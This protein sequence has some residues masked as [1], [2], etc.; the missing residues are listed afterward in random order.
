LPGLKE[1]SGRVLDLNM[2]EWKKS[3]EL[4]E[5]ASIYFNFAYRKIWKIKSIKTINQT[6][7]GIDEGIDKILVLEDNS[8]I[9]IE[10][11]VRAKKYSNN[12][13]V[14]EEKSNVEK[15]TPGWI[16][17][18]KADYLAYSW[19]IDGLAKVLIIKMDKLKKWYMKNKE[20]YNLVTTHTDNLYHTSF[21]II[22]LSDLDFEFF[23]FD[24]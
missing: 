4:E 3:L 22:P 18:S 9:T 24:L 7:K 2:V 17:Y 20:K 23:K 6:S 11:K 19:F 14:I 1:T 16:Y 21:R 13:L 12:D 5:K 15:N 10:E 8:Q